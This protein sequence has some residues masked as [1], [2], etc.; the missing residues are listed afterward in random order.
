IA[1][2][3]QSLPSRPATG[4]ATGTYYALN[5][6][7]PGFHPDGRPASPANVPPA[8][9]GS[10]FVFVPPTTV[11]TIGD[12]LIA[13]NISWR[14]YGGGLNDAVAGRPNAYC[15]ICNPMQFASSIMTNAA[16]RT[17]HH[18]DVVDLYTDIANNTLPAVSFV[19]PSE[20]VDG[21]PLSSK[22]DLFE[23]FLRNI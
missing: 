1:N 14:C 13:K 6:L 20:L 16:V 18:K 2:Y 9:D 11:P 17:A 3:L 4:C 19:K 23:A 15:A 10:D 21:H 22:L 5:N 7:F 8:S 12:A